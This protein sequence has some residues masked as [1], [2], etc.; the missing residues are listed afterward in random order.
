MDI[1]LVQEGP[2]RFRVDQQEPMRVPGV[3]FATQ[4]LLPQAVGDKA[5]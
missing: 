4:D 3:V 2:F 5:L 1:T